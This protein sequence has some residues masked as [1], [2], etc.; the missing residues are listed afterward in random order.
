MNPKIAGILRHTIT[1]AAGILVTTG[2]LNVEDANTLLGAAG[3]FAS[4]MWSIF[5]PEKRA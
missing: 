3:G 1:F 2:K 5:A 4:L